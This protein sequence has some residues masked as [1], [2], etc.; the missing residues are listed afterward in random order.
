MEKKYLPIGTVCT[1]KGE[2]KQVM[3][4]GFYSVKYNGNLKIN[5]YVG[6]YY[7]EGMLIPEGVVSFNHTDIESVDYLGYKNEEN[8]KFQ[9]LLNQITGNVDEDSKDE[10]KQTV[11][12]TGIYSK[13][14]F[15]ENGVV[16]Y[17]EPVVANQ[18]GEDQVVEQEK[19]E[20]SGYGRIEFD[21]NG[22]VIRA[23]FDTVDNPFHK[24]YEM[25]KK[26]KEV[27]E[28]KWKIFDKLD[29]TEEDDILSL[30]PIPSKSESLV[31][32]KFDDDGTVL[33]EL[34]KTMELPKLSN[35]EFDDDGSIIEANSVKAA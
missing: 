15:D 3:I 33:E 27:P 26:P 8:T 29:T 25:D 31:S 30:D 4:T 32:V 16:T 1:I 35:I 10:S 24:E 22:Y 23:D 18:F 11:A 2:N 7:P 17:A 14:M 28:N 13:I 12:E 9:T 6:C 19:K 21:E 20:N 5:D 34:D